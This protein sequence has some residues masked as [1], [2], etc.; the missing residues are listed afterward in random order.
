MESKRPSSLAQRGSPLL[1]AGLCLLAAS[2][3]AAAG[4]GPWYDQL[5][6]PRWTPPDWVF[7][8]VWTPL[9][10]MIALAGWL[11]QRSGGWRSPATA[12]WL[13]QLALNAGWTW[14]FFGLQRPGWALVDILLLAAAIT[15][16]IVLARRTSRTAALLLA[17]YLVWVL[18]ATALN[19]AIWRMNL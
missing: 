2:A 19:G 3:G 7:P 15:A 12:M 16:T 1:F 6:K 13:G 4:P 8:V 5:A 11:I 17:P 18:F 9:Y 10:A 14:L